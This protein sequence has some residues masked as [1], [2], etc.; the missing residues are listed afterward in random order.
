MSYVIAE[1]D[2]IAAAAADVAAI[3]ST[4]DVANM[5]AALPTVALAPAAADEVSAGIAQLFSE[6][7]R[8]YQAAA[9]QAA[10]SLEQFGE[11][12]V[13]S[14]GLYAFVEAVSASFLHETKALVRE[15][16]IEVL[17]EVLA[18]VSPLGHAA[19]VPLFDVIRPQ[20]DQWVTSNPGLASFFVGAFLILLLL[21]AIALISLGVY[22]TWAIPAFFSANPALSGLVEFIAAA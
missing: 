22:T 19:L 12:L 6:H 20:L 1:P 10:A 8:D 3:G 13:R 18:V 11:N 5:A 15:V 14:S 21:F 2:V 16:L 17:T 4:L 7:A 9:R